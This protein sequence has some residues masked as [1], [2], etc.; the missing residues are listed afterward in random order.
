M[1]GKVGDRSP[2]TVE[3]LLSRGVS[4][5]LEGRALDVVLRCG[6]PRPGDPL[7]IKPC[8]PIEQRALKH[9]IEVVDLEDGRH[10]KT[11][12]QEVRDFLHGQLRMQQYVRTLYLR[13]VEGERAG[14]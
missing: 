3:E 10:A 13:T 7:G 4:D 5:D 14:S 1:R 8:I 9:V 11:K 6:W 12:L 2:I